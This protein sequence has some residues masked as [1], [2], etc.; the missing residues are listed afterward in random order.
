[1][2]HTMYDVNKHSTMVIKYFVIY[3]LNVS[4][5]VLKGYI[6]TLTKVNSP[7]VKIP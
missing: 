5:L 6:G 1:M 4:W 3:S 2:T 7:T